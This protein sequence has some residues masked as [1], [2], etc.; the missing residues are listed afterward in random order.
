MSSSEAASET[1]WG[2]LQDCRI[3]GRGSGTC[4]GIIAGS[5]CQGTG[6]TGVGG[7]MCGRAELAGAGR[8]AEDMQT[9]PRDPRMT[10]H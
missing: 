4:S 10:Q 8:R 5:A 6:L 3:R 1:A 9:I 7:L 2:Y